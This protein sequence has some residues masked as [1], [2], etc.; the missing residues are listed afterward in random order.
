MPLYE[1]QCPKC[2]KIAGEVR[3]MNDSSLSM[4]CPTC[5]IPMHRKYDFHTGN[6]EY[7][8]TRF[9]NSLAI[10]PSQIA[11]HKKLFPDIRVDSSGR[12]GFDNYKQHDDYLKKTGF[13]K[14]PQ[15]TRPKK[16]RS[17]V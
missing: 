6:R 1:F 3:P 15:K 17:M 10:N 16:R 11:E 2:G 12:P 13:V 8:Q 9:S 5:N 7:G 4:M 14:M